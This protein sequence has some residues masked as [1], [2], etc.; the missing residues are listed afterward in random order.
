MELADRRCGAYVLA[1]MDRLFTVRDFES[2]TRFLSSKSCLL[3]RTLAGV[4][5]ARRFFFRCRD[6]QLFPQNVT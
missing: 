2:I 3:M 4:Q 1:V 5:I 6:L